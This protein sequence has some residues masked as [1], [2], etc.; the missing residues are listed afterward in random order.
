MDN[1]QELC[2]PKNCKFGHTVRKRSW[3]TVQARNLRQK[4]MMLLDLDPQG[5]VFVS[6]ID[7]SLACRMM[8]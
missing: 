6:C 7:E 5:N 8:R 1:G 4:Q 3:S 2:L